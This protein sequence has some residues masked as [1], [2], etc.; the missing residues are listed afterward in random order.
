MAQA[1]RLVDDATGSLAR[2][3]DDVPLGRGVRFDGAAL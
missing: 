3:A 1:G 2:P